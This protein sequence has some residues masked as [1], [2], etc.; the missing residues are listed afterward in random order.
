MR[1][2][3]G[4]TALIT[5]GTSGIGLATAKQFHAAG[6]RVI[7]TGQ[8]AD[9]LAAACAELPTDVLVLR[10]DSRNLNDAIALAERIRDHG[11]KLDIVFL[12]AGIAKLRPFAAT[13]E[14]F[15][16]EQFDINVKGPI[17]TLQKL[18]P[19]LSPGA[20]VILNTSVASI[21]GA[22]HLSIY[23]ATKGALAALTRALAVELAPN[24]I[25]VNAIAPATIKTP[26]QKKFGLPEEMAAAVQHAY[27]AKIPLGRFG[28][29]DEVA[30]LALFLASDAASYVSGTEI[31]VDGGLFIS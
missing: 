15:Y 7:I 4:K 29:A 2:L 24:K 13:D 16:D 28:E 25:R 27:E 30:A 9:T 31:P 18:L 23:S 12:N 22:A 8:N 17:F 20:S 5:G 3:E 14:A 6:A 26:I 21:R 19:L 1:I 11:T 10:A